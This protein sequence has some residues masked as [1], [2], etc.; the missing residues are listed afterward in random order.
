MTKPYWDP[1][2][3]NRLE[4]SPL[5]GGRTWKLTAPFTIRFPE[6][7]VEKYDLP[8]RIM[9][10]AQGFRHDGRSTPIGFRWLL[11]RTGWIITCAVTHDH[12]FGLPTEIERL[13]SKLRNNRSY[14]NLSRIT[15]LENQLNHLNDLLQYTRYQ[16]D[17]IYFEHQKAVVHH[18]NLNY[19]LAM[20]SNSRY[21]HFMSRWASHGLLRTMSWTAW[22]AR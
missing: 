11:K 12:L 15:S 10:M 7:L 16:A 20:P 19:V 14:Y 18:N 4:D 2:A 3:L 13:Q 8:T 6:W 22:Q 21:G 5:P 9:N 1:W 17:V